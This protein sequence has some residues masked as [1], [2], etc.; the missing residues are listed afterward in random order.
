MNPIQACFLLL[1]AALTAHSLPPKSAIFYYSDLP[2]QYSITYTEVHPDARPSPNE[3]ANIFRADYTDRSTRKI[4]LQKGED[5]PHNIEDYFTMGWIL[6][7]IVFVSC[8][9]G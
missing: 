6:T 5:N 2:P 7:G 3:L 9:G 8:F 4:N 1:A